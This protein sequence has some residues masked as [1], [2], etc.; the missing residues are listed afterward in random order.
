[1]EDD[2]AGRFRQTLPPGSGQALLGA[3]LLHELEVFPVHATGL[4]SLLADGGR[5]PKEAQVGAVTEVRHAAPAICSCRTCACGGQG[6]P[7]IARACARAHA[8]V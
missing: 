3:A 4:P 6:R 7:D 8:R 5:S 1:M 2:V